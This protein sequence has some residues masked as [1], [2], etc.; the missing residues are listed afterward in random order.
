MLAAAEM[1]SIVIPVL[2]E[3]ATIAQALQRLAPL[4]ERGAEVIVVDGGSSDATAAHARPLADRVERAPRGRASQMNAGAALARG[5]TLMFLHA[6]TVLPDDADRLI[7][8]A[9][10]GG[11]RWGRFDV[12]IEGTHPMLAVVAWSMNLR[13]R[14]SGIA[15]GD[16][17][18]FVCRETFAA[19]G[20]FPDIA[21][22]E[23]IALSRALKQRGRPACLRARVTTSG[24]RWQKHG[25]LRTIA[26]MWRLR[27]AYFLGADPSDLA[28]R[29]GYRPARR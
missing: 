13:S 4:R 29:Y 24:R 5:D 23:D 6:D 12:R 28:V 7:A 21:L 1:L 14:L 8:A 19:A 22:M 3:A 11:A 17:A 9:L 15:T 18:M 10:A 2:D 16:Q 27:L 26:L 25:V 20:G